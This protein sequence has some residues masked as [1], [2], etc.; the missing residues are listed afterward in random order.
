MENLARVKQNRA[1][2]MSGQ[3]A[4]E[5]REVGEAAEADGSRTESLGLPSEGSYRGE[6]SPS[7]YLEHGG[8]DVRG[9]HHAAWTLIGSW[10]MIV[11][12]H[13]HGLG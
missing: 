1:W 7:G 11:E 3:S 9:A 6:L 8:G 5:I 10:M 13:P 12:E 4:D 2:N